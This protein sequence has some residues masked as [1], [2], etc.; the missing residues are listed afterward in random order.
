[1]SFPFAPDFLAGRPAIPVVAGDTLAYGG[2]V[3]GLDGAVD[4]GAAMSLLTYDPPGDTVVDIVLACTMAKA[5]DWATSGNWVVTIF[6]D[7][8]ETGGWAVIVSGL[9]P[10]L[11]GDLKFYNKSAPDPVL[12]T[13]RIYF[14]V[15]SPITP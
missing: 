1:M 5:A 11:V 3:T 9:T 6:A 8:E 14:P 4:W 10:L 15:G 2:I 7:G 13:T 12:H